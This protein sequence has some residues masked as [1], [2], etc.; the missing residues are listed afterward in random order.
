MKI[1]RNEFLQTNGGHLEI[2]KIA[3]PLVLGSAAH[4]V[5][6]LSDRIMLSHYSAEAVAASLGGGITA[7]SIACFFLGT[8]GFTGSFVAQYYGAGAK[9][10][11][12]T[13]V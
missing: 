6:L 7:F 10:R 12:G 3:L 1:S 5:N 8:V 9:E 11:V 4:S 2:L 13:A